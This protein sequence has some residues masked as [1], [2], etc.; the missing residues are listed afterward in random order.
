MDLSVDGWRPLRVLLTN[1]QLGEPGGSEVNLRDWA[2]G[3][4][5]RG[6]RPMAYAPVLGRVADV[7]RARSIPVVDNLSLVTEPP[8]LVHGSHTPTVLEA[9]VRFPRVPVIQICQAV[10]YPMSEPLL[11]RQVRRHVAVDEA[12]RDYLVTEGGVPGAQIHV[13]YNALDLA[14]IPPRRSPLPPQPTR[15]LI[16]TKTKAQIP[17]LEEACRLQGLPFDTLGRGVDRVVLEPEQELPRY[18]LVFATAR[19]AMEAIASGAATIVVDGR[20]FAGMVTRDNVD[21]LRAHNFGRRSLVHDVTVDRILT[22]IQQYNP[23][24]AAEVSAHLRAVADIESQ[25]DVFEKIYAAILKEASSEVFSEAELLEQLVPILHNWL[26]RFPGVT[27]QWQF[28]KAALLNR[29]SELDLALA[30]ERSGP[31]RKLRKYLR[32]YPRAENILVAIVQAFRK[33]P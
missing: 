3:L 17:V 20:G 12:N 33:K 1:H 24:D 5:R 2:I 6:H 11:L 18:D 19:S 26:P 31:S 30:H 16:Y 21:R 32:R 28:E 4:Q 14:R 10:G 27:W 22:E 7:L 23:A 29:I 8:D 13:L 15:A 9:I 25:L